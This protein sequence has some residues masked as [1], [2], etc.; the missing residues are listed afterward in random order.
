MR[1]P[2]KRDGIHC[3]MADVGHRTGSERADDDDSLCHSFM[4]LIDS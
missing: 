2:M 1:L 3:C 4:I